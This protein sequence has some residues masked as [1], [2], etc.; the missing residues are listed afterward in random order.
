MPIKKTVYEYY[1]GNS[2]L[3]NEFILLIYLPPPCCGAHRYVYFF[4][5]SFH[6]WI[7]ILLT[8][9]LQKIAQ[10][11]SDWIRTTGGQQGFF[12]SKFDEKPLRIQHALTARIHCKDNV[13]S[14]NLQCLV[15][16]KVCF[17]SRLKAQTRETVYMFS[18]S[19]NTGF[20]T[21]FFPP[22]HSSMKLSFVAHSGHGGLFHPVP[23]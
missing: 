23:T 7:L 6:I 4:F 16:T 21:A 22:C 14:F 18:T 10:T 19:Q 17:M 5:L 3:E 1:G 13:L 9:L 2:L 12:P 15:S 11:T 20:H 8:S